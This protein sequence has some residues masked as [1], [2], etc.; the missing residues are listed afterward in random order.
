MDRQNGLRGKVAIV[1]GGPAGLVVAKY[2][3]EQGFEPTLFEQ[4]DSIGGQW[5]ARASHSGVWPSMPT[6]TSRVMTCFSDFQHEPDTVVYPSEQEMLSY[7]QRY[8]AHFDLMPHIRVRTRIEL[9][10]RDSSGSGWMVRFVPEDGE[11]QMETFPYVIVASGRYNKPLIPPV[12]GLDSFSGPGGVTHT[13]HYRDPERYRGQ[14]VLVAG[15]SISALE[16]ASDLAMHGRT[17]IVSTFRRQR[18]IFQKLLAGVPADHVAFTRFAVL[19]AEVMPMES[20]AQ[21]LKEF[22]LRTSG[23]PEQFGALRPADNV[24]EAGISLSQHYLPLVAEGHIVPKPWIGAVEGQTVRFV[25]GSVEQ[26][27][28]IIFGTGYDLD[29]PFLS[30][31]VRRTLDLNAHHIDLY[32]STFHPDLAGLAFLG[33]FELIGPYFPVLELQA[34]WIAYT[35]SGVRPAP[36]REEMEAGLTAYRARRGQP[37]QQLMDMMALLF[38]REAGVEPELHEWPEFA[39]ALLF[40][41]LAST[42]FRL[43]GPDSLP[44][45]AEHFASDA[46]A[47]GAITSP[48]FTPDQR[49]R[50]EALIAARNDAAFAEFVKQVT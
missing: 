42:S 11:P 43:S 38:A 44:E 2:L 20:I 18:Y 4:S 3:K 1:G 47:F 15:G 8:A 12:P 30:E 36:S 26:I 28:A 29:V 33:L 40:G 7:L 21:G 27:D 16:I 24:L 39:R 13:F 49:A 45:A 6:N 22:V 5:N 9:I 50:L 17:P 19:S 14:R 34:R 48:E 41:P 37:Q 31:E 23:S 25:D 35:W 46:M 10:E 32:K